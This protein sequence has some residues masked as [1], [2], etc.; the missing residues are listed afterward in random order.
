MNP[1]LLVQAQRAS[2]LFMASTLFPA[3]LRGKSEIETLGNAVMVFALAERMNEQV[4]MVAQN[5]YFVAGKAGWKTEY[6]VSRANQSGVF[7]GRIRWRSEG[8]GAH[9]KVTAYATLK[10]D[11]SPVEATVSM[12]MAHAEGWTKNSKYKSMPE[13]MLRWRAATFLIR[14][15]CPEVMIGI[16]SRDELDDMRAA[17]ALDVSPPPAVSF[18][19]ALRGEAIDG[20]PR[21]ERPSSEA[22]DGMEDGT[23][24]TEGAGGGEGKRP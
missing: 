10:G 2:K 6:M 4:L 24:E 20:T 21:Q 17:G 8:E 5:I 14:L 13:H 12:E 1:A 11:E 16:A 3:H 22:L 7:Q 15:Y 23:R 18:G 9:L 19:D